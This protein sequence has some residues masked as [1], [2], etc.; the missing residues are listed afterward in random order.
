[1]KKSKFG[2]IVFSAVL[3]V[4]FCAAPV[5]ADVVA[6]PRTYDFGAVYVGDSATMR[7]TFINAEGDKVSISGFEW[8][9]NPLGAFQVVDIAF[10]G[11][12]LSGAS[13]DYQVTFTPPD[14]S[15]W[16]ATLRIYTSS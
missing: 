5:C 12:L 7:G 6:K 13:V 14:F 2:V 3:T 10:L 11:V 8:T 16:N 4:L 1:M 9:Y 15:F